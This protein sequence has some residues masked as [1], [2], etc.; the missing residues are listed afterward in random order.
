[1]KTGIATVSICGNLEEKI[2]AIAAAGI[3]GIEVF[4]Q[5]FVVDIRSPRDVGNR[6]RVAGLEILPFQPFRDFEGLPQPLRVRAFDRFE[7]KFDL[8]QDPGTDLVLVCSSVHPEALGGSG[9]AA[10][11]FCRTGRTG[12]ADWLGGAGMGVPCQ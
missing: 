1:M 12:G 11:D 10:A 2:E 9:R 3:S 5:D 4:E 8:M 6:V 7:R